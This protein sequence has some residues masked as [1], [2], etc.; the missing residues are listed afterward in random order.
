MLYE[1]TLSK[2]VYSNCLT[3][4][5]YDEMFTDL[6]KYY[7]HKNFNCLASIIFT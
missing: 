6:N 4:L 1:Y 7:F 2:F 5:K 3:L